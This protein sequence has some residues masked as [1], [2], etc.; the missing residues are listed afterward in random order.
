MIDCT[1]CP[2]RASCCGVMIFKNDFLEK[3]KDKIQGIPK[4]IISQGDD[5]YYMYEDFKC[6]F[7]D[8]EKLI[9]VIYDDRPEVCKKYGVTDDIRLMCPYFKPNGNPWSSAKRKQLERKR[10]RILYENSTLC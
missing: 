10:G 6:P 7:L 4:E 1:K 9:C 2:D 5:V 8:R 3:Y